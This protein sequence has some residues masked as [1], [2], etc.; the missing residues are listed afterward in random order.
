[1]T[2]V[3]GGAGRGS[4][5]WIRLRF[6]ST[7]NI[8]Q[9]KV[10]RIE[11]PNNWHVPYFGGRF[12]HNSQFSVDSEIFIFIFCI[13]QRTCFGCTDVPT[14]SVR[15]ASTNLLFFIKSNWFQIVIC[16]KLGFKI[17]SCQNWNGLWLSISP[18]LYFGTF[19][20]IC[21]TLFLGPAR[22]YSWVLHQRV[23]SV[24]RVSP[25]MCWYSVHVRHATEGEIAV[26]H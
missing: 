18:Y 3:P 25:R 8:W 19:L 24:S 16:C 26:R 17:L 20:L 14:E 10:F 4:Y 6:Q 23:Y 11:L 21:R 5:Y 22:T 13:I 9:G 15:H 2:S 1:M 7:Q 12:C